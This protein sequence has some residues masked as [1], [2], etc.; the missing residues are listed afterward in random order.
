MK[1]KSQIL[2]K[3]LEHVPDSVRLWKAVVELANEEDARVLLLRA[4]E[5]C[6]MH[7]ELWLALAR[8]ETYEGAKKVLKRARMKLSKEPAI[9]ITAAKLEEAN[10]N[11]TKVG[12]VIERGI[13]ALQ[14]QGLVLDREGWMM[15]AEAAERAGF[16][17]TCQA[18]IRNTVGI[19]VEEEDLE[20]T[21]IA[22]A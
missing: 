3:G 13:H 18:I 4:V 11:T 12:E 21:W 16:V 7:I 1:K 2:R 6:P 9:W 14:G 17:V 19:G 10:G 8:L 5:C 15:V 22:D 20:M